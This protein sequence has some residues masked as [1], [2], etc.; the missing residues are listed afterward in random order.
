MTSTT[1]AIAVKAMNIIRKKQNKSETQIL[2]VTGTG[3][4]FLFLVIPLK[5]WSQKPQELAP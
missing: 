3:F 2:G 4:D 1:T 5:K